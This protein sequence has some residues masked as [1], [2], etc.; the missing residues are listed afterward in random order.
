VRWLIPT[1][2]RDIELPGSENRGILRD[3]RVQHKLGRPL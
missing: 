3:A 2:T 1:T